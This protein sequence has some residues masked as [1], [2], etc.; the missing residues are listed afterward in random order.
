YDPLADLVQSSRQRVLQSFPQVVD[1]W[2]ALNKWLDNTQRGRFGRST[3]RPIA[4]FTRIGYPISQCML[5][6]Q[7]VRRLPAFFRWASPIPEDQPP[8]SVLAPLL[9]EW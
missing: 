7:D 5:R 8:A 6:E 1:G 4:G 2:I 3:A 9:V